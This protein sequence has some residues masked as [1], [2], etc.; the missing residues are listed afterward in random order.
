MLS[1]RGMSH[2]PFPVDCSYLCFVSGNRHG[3]V[4]RVYKFSALRGR[5]CFD[6]EHQVRR[7]QYVTDTARLQVAMLDAGV[8][9]LRFRFQFRS[10]SSSL[11]G[12]LLLTSHIHVG[13]ERHHVTLL[14]MCAGSCVVYC[15]DRRG[16][17]A[18]A[19]GCGC[20]CLFSSSLLCR[21]CSFVQVSEALYM[22]RSCL[23]CSSLNF[24]ARV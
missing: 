6:C 23:S 9:S 13:V 17:C 10:F 24:V 19:C 5:R 14:S 1:L 4:V 22:M 12:F 7:W 21:L 2:T 8:V 3:R 18:C 11:F 16:G 15:T 20:G